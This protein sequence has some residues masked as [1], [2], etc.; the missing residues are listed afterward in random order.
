MTNGSGASLEATEMVHSNLIVLWGTNTR[1]TNRHLW[2][3]IEQ[4]RD[5]G[6]RLI[7]IDPIRTLTADAVDA[8]RGDRFIQ[9][10]P[11][12]DVAMMLAMMHVIIRDDLHDAAWVTDHT[13]G[14]DEL[15]GAVA[16]WTPARA[17]EVCG[18]DA[19]EIETLAVNAGWRVREDCTPAEQERRYLA[20]RNDRLA[21][22]SFAYLLHLE[23]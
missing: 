18:L 9:P 6:A 22:P 7:V 20:G 17:A 2:P 11:G 14:F 8:E 4:A 5:N 15:R 10:L 23:R 16:D 21:V 12:T 19:D 3:T 1:L 13:L